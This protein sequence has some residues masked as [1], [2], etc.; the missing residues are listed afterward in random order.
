MRFFDKMYITIAMVIIAPHLIVGLTILYFE[1]SY[2]NNKIT[3]Y[4]NIDQRKKT[5]FITI[6]FSLETGKAAANHFPELKNV[7]DS[8]LL[9]KGYCP[10]QDRILKLYKGNNTYK[11][12]CYIVNN[13]IGECRFYNNTL[14]KDSVT[15]FC[16]LILLLL[17]ISATTALFFIY[18]LSNQI[19]AP[20]ERLADYLHNKKDDDFTFNLEL[21]ATLELNSLS[22]KIKS[23]LLKL[24]NYCKSS[25]EQAKLASIG[26]TTAM[27]AHDVR[28]PFTMLQGTLDLMAIEDE[29]D[30]LKKIAR[31]ALPEVKRAI[32]AVNG[33]IDDVMEVGS[34]AAIKAE[35]SSLGTLIE[36]IIID[37]FNYYNNTM[38]D[39]KYDLKHSR[40]LL[41]D[42]FRVAR[43][44]ANII[45]NAIQAMKTKGSLFFTSR[46]IQQDAESYIEIGIRNTGS[47]I[48]I[49]D[50]KQLF[51]AFFTKGKKKGT[52]LGLAIAKKIIQA[53]GGNIHCRSSW[54]MGTEFIFT[55]P[56]STEYDVHRTLPQSSEYIQLHHSHRSLCGPE[57]TANEETRLETAI[58]ETDPEHK[59]KIL[60]VEDEV[61]YQNILIRQLDKN[62]QLEE[63]TD[64]YLAKSGEE[65]VKLEMAT[66][67]DV[68]L[69]DVDLG[70]TKMNGFETV[71][72]LRHHGSD[73]VICVNSNR[74]ALEYGKIALSYGAQSF[75]PKPMVRA[76]L[77]KII[78]SALIKKLSKQKSALLY[79]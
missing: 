71:K 20:I 50:Q 3:S 65:A 36:N 51:D 41:I 75:L 72:A 15:K 49:D 10:T 38:V 23:Y 52:G 58:I 13:E 62:K 28:K 57:E 5:E 59:I 4:V 12:V 11:G 45:D 30:E 66:N 63:K 33:M 18:I 56:A 64:L 9:S 46:D 43:V 76:H 47:Y 55:L 27:L 32:S 37:F 78:H 19:V 22:S 77:L 14:L 8:K 1:Y 7:Y 6:R 48:H 69:V 39:I 61:L 70:H 68:I 73:A 2:I 21:N 79:Q 53:H 40:K 17:I 29:P 35:P 24:H 44:F 16:R 74:G 54:E 31:E 26:K 67:F 42:R 34:N 25:E 60:I